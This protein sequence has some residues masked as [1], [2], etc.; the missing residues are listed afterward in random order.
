[1]YKAMEEKIKEE[2]KLLIRKAKLELW[3]G[4]RSLALTKTKGVGG[5][6]TLNLTLW[7][8]SSVIPPPQSSQLLFLYFIFVLFH[9]LA[10]AGLI[11]VICLFMNTDAYRFHFNLICSNYMV[12]LHYDYIVWLLHSDL[13][14]L[15][16]LFS[17]KITLMTSVFFL[18]YFIYLF[19]FFANTATK[20]NN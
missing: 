10:T 6:Q 18:L 12:W 11:Q 16:V 19:L 2:R 17:V 3:F 20:Q 1:M 14:F 8:L 4:M 9:P 7:K 13:I 5:K 15:H